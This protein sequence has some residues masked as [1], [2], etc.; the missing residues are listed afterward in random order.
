[1]I[2]TQS[3]RTIFFLLLTG[4]MLSS[5]R[6][7]ELPVTPPDLGNITTTAIE[8]TPTYEYQVYF[9]LSSN[10]NKGKNHK[11]DWDLGFSCASG[12][13][14]IITNT[15]KVML[16]SL[17]QDKTFEEI[18]NTS[19]F[20]ISNR[21][22]YPTGFVDSL[23]VRG[24][25]L[26]ILD[27]GFDGVGNHQGYF[28]MEILE[29]D[30][31][32]FKGRFANIDGSNEQ[33]ITIQKDDTYN[34]VYMKWNPSGTITT[35]TIEPAKE[36]WDL[37][38]TQFTEIFYEPDFM[39]YSVVGCLTNTFNTKSLRVTEKTFD[40]IDLAY[41]EGLELSIDR[42]VIGYNWKTFLYD[43]NTFLVHHEKVYII[44]DNEGYFYK[45]RFIDFY[46]QLGQKGTPTFEYQRL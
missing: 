29:H 1:M 4:L 30:N 28:K 16:V 2:I 25:S 26:F 34:F 8:L 20:S 21:A 37:V 19:N 18:S 9:D 6:K 23:A 43:Q 11:T 5:C 44:Q 36:E 10:S 32:H 13:P 14:Y 45:L 40:E 46:N 24:G 27:R 22:D 7:D 41:A 17:V 39:P 42:D 15:S 38:F 33:I 12:T 3:N 31:T 35:P